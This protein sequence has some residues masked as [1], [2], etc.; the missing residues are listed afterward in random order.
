MLDRVWRIVS[1][2]G[3]RRVAFLTD[4]KP[5]QKQDRERSYDKADDRTHAFGP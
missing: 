4:E 2:V 3:P 5:G 1:L